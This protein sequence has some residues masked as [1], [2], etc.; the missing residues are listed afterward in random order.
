MAAG[1]LRTDKFGYVGQRAWHGMGEEIPAGMKAEDAF[2]KLGIDWDTMLI[3]AAGVFGEGE[4]RSLIEIP[5]RFLHIRVKDKM[6]LG[7]VSDIYRIIPNMEMARFA[8][9]LVEQGTQVAT[10]TAGTLHNGKRVFTTVKLPKNIEV[11]NDDILEMYLVLSNS[12]DGS[13]AFHIYSSSVRVVC[14]NTL[15]LSERDLAKGIRMQHS[16]RI[17]NKVEKARSVLGLVVKETEKYEEDIRM[18][19]RLKLNKAEATKY[20]MAVYN[21]VFGKITEDDEEVTKDG[22]IVDAASAKTRVEHRRK[23]IAHW[24][25]LMDHANQNK[26]GISGSGW[27]AFNAFTQWSDHERGNMRGVRESDVR[28]HSNVFGIGNLTKRRAWKKVLELV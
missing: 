15:T 26:K 2:V 16:G 22:V 24:L 5:D 12:H 14:Q 23:M 28:I 20:F 9:A 10:E 17:D 13:A 6:P 7:L 1:I 21:V 8:D 3:P 18:V 25:E 4:D 27:A 11:V 19:V